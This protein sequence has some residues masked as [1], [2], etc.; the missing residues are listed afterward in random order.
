MRYAATIIYVPDVAAEIAWY[1][2]A[3]GF[4]SGGPGNAQYDTLAIDGATI[5]FAAHEV[6]PGG[7]PGSPSAF[8]L[9]LETTDVAGAYE[10][11]LVA[12]AEAVQP[13]ERKPWG[14]TV[15]YVRDPAGAARPS[16]PTPSAAWSCDANARAPPSPA[17][18]A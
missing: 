15:A 2:R 9:W 5:A 8:E 11:A 18:V 12:G 17:R 13:P 1:G 3:F 7:D 6:A 16:S 10:G 14:Q 4:R